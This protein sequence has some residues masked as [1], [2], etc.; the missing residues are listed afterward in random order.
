M[1]IYFDSAA[2]TQLDE[3]VMEAM[4]NCMKEEVGNPSSTH[5][6]GRKAK[7]K[8]ENCRREIAAHLGAQPSEIIFT[9]CGTESDNMTIKCAIDDLGVTR[10]I[11]SEIEHKAVL[12]TVKVLAGDK[13][14]IDYVKVNEA[15][16]VDLDHLEEL[17]SSSDKKTLVTLMHA[18]N[19]IGTI[20]PMKKVGDLCKTYKAYFH[21]DTVQTVGHFPINFEEMGV[22]FAACSAHKIH[23]PQ[24]VGFLYLNKKIA[25]NSMLIGG[26]QERGLRAGTENLIGITGLTKSIELAYKTLDKDKAYILELRNY[27]KKQLIAQ[28]GDQ[29]RFN[30]SE[31][32]YLYTVLSVCFPNNENNGLLLFK[33]DMKGIA[34]SGGSAC[35]S[36][37]NLGSHVI[38]GIYENASDYAPMRIS[39][40]KH[41][42][43]EEIDTCMEA[44]KELV[45]LNETT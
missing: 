12:T 27:M 3:Q 20:L 29:I 26:G 9:S 22:H 24:G 19:E 43:K 40:S 18:N 30:G 25:L 36:G 4:V 31:T 16:E 34:L 39:F 35:N 2:T 44:L 6:F 11:S 13:V 32:D 21:S 8:V 1:A 28:F 41:N 23:G 37:A 42:T 45:E 38:N 14:T 5:S 7:N 15:G 33:L 17:L 10:I